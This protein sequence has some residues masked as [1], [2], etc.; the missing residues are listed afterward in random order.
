MHAHVFTNKCNEQHEHNST[1]QKHFFIPPLISIISY[2]FGPFSETFSFLS[3]QARYCSCM[4]FR[5]SNAWASCQIKHCSRTAS[6]QKMLSTWHVPAT[7]WEAPITQAC[8]QCSRTISIILST[9]EERGLS[10][11]LS[12]SV[13]ASQQWWILK[14]SLL[15]KIKAASEV[16]DA[17]S[18]L[19]STLNHERIQ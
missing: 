9:S 1:A 12:T 15:V 16:G 17:I 10:S 4:R 5:V 6:K 13:G 19:S 14:K 2:F 11:I 7:P 3:L 18:F 8:T